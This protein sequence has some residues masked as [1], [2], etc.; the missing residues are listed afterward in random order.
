[1]GIFNLEN[2]VT[3]KELAPSLQQLIDSKATIL[4]YTDCNEIV[5]RL[6]A[7]LGANRISITSS[8]NNV[9]TPQ[10]DKEILC[11]TTNNLFYSYSGG[12]HPTGGVY[13]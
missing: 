9:V 6:S 3:Y 12:W 13:S 11:L 10:N 7:Q 8:G 2:K 4:Q 1:M 5:T